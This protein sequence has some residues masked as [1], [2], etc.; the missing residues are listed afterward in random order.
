MRSAFEERL[1][2]TSIVIKI[3]KNKNETQQ[4]QVKK[5]RKKVS[6][7]KVKQ[8]K[9]QS[10]KKSHRINSKEFKLLNS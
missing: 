9:A 5:S 1:S 3:I 8:S 6:S 7:S 10:K 4:D 2:I